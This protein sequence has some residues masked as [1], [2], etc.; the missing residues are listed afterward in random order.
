MSQV[1]FHCDLS[2]G[3]H[4]DRFHSEQKKRIQS[5]RTVSNSDKIRMGHMNDDSISFFTFLYPKKSARALG[6]ISGHSLFVWI[7]YML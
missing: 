6:A 3:V 2:R 1:V 5:L 7:K 4:S